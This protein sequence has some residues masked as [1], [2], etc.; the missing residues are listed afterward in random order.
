M[1]QVWQAVAVSSIFLLVN[2]LAK[3][4]KIPPI[5]FL[6]FVY[7]DSSIDPKKFCEPHA[8]LWMVPGPENSQMLDAVD[9][10]KTNVFRAEGITPGVVGRDL[11][12][13]EMKNGRVDP[14][15][16]LDGIYGIQKQRILR[17][18]YACL[19]RDEQVLKQLSTDFSKIEILNGKKAP[20]GDM[21][22][23]GSI[24]NLLP[25][26]RSSSAQMDAQSKTVTYC[27]PITEKGLFFTFIKSGTIWKIETSKGMQV[28]LK[29]FFAENPNGRAIQ[30]AP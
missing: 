25:I 2:P 1:H 27:V 16:F 20:L 21:D 30:Y 10:L 3:A 8:D 26:V 13:L 19:R 5:Q 17:F 14:S 18:L 6:R 11:Y 28:D 24:L 9:A 23:Y 12:F 15:F 7:G 22:V 29:Y 4:E